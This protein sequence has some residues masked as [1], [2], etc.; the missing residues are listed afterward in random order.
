MKRI[1]IAITCS[2]LLFASCK[3]TTPEKKSDTVMTDNPLLTE[4][5]T[6]FGVPPFDKIKS[7][8]YLP[9]FKIALEENKQEIKEIT[10]NTEAPTFQNTIEALEF[11]GKNLNRIQRVFYA[12]NSANT[13]SIL[14]IA[15]KE[16]TPAI[17]THNDNINLNPAL[18]KRIKAVYDQKETLNLS[19]EE[20]RLLEE[21]HKRFVRSGI[22][23]EG[24]AQDRLHEI[25]TRLAA[26]GGYFG[27][28]L[29]D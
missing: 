26:L 9:A 27:E 22:N 24:K 4:W 29:L 8:D 3:E 15:A 18:F 7:S 6:P 19:S 12:V 21:T 14:K 25:N 11:S 10:E 1:S 28:N 20:S 5:N 16:I 2:I 23:L 13:D 17:A